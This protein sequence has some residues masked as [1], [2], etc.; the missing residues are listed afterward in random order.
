MA[1]VVTRVGS[2][3]PLLKECAY[4]NPKRKGKKKT[5]AFKSKHDNVSTE[6]VKKK[7]PKDVS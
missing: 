7:Q 3:S 6:L 2:S 4:A 5:I 1:M